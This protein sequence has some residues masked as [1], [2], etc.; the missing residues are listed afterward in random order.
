MSI[1]YETPQDTK[2]PLGT[3][4]FSYL[5]YTDG[6]KRTYVGATNDPDRR[7][8]QHNG[9]ISGGAFAT[10]G[11][12]W[13]RALYVGGFPDWQTTLQF[14]WAWKHYS[15][16]QKYHGLHG[17]L[18]GLLHLLQLDKPTSKAVPYCMWS[19]KLYI[20][21]EY[22]SNTDLEKIETYRRVMS[23][24]G[25]SHSA[26]I[27][28]PSNPSNPS[29]TSFLSNMSSTSDMSSIA[30]LAIQ[31]DLLS[32]EVKALSERLTDALSKIDANENNP[33]TADK[34]V[35]KRS[36]KTDATTATD[37]TNT[38]TATTDDAEKKTKK[39]RKPREAKEKPTCPDA[40]EGV[41]RF[42][43]SAGDNP[44]KVFSNLA[45]A[46][47][48]IDGKSYFSVENYIQ[49]EKFAT[50]DPEYAEKIRVQKNP[51]L[52]KGMGKSKAHPIPEDWDSKRLDVLRKGLRAKFTTHD[53]LK[54]KLLATGNAKIEEESPSDSFLGIG[55]DG[56]GMNWSG[57]LLMELRDSLRA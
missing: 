37:T 24:V 17:K 1:F 34:P 8:R 28:N 25:S 44:Y 16:K 31:V 41:I 57:K 36:K 22:G 15:R 47:F 19:H 54:E 43:S 42:Y 53:D 48:T 55:V 30:S 32:N 45:K 35:K 2:T 52:V 38:N 18:E 12:K 14:E 5:L 3:G 7:L 20:H 46:E 49:S 26:Y 50:T 9:E 29:N 10:K 39:V 51:A 4:F 27:S 23:A 21:T 13:K 11:R 33:I 6:G 40:D 56:Q